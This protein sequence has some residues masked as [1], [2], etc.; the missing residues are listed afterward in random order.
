MYSAVNSSYPYELKYTINT[1]SSFTNTDNS[2]IMQFP[3]RIICPKL[4]FDFVEITSAT[5][6]AIKNQN[7]PVIRQ[8]YIFKTTAE[9]PYLP[10]QKATGNCTNHQYL[11]KYQ[12]T[13]NDCTTLTSCDQDGCGR[14]KVFNSSAR[15]YWVG[16][17][18]SNLT[19]F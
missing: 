15:S 1:K 2:V 11:I 4:K 16:S 9:N 14:N 5:S 7:C 6:C 17:N 19:T 18:P 10:V 8:I 3:R 13:E 12:I